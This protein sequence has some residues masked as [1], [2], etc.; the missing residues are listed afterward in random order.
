MWV[1][2]LLRALD[3]D[4]LVG[5]EEEVVDVVDMVSEVGEDVGDDA[6]VEDAEVD[7]SDVV[8]DDVV[9]DNGC[10]EVGG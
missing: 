2:R 5:V 6:D 7:E 8:D 9:R 1:E 4:M 3:N 10:E